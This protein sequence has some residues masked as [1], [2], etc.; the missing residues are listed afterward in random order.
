MYSYLDHGY[1]V[2]FAFNSCRQILGDVP[3]GGARGQNLGHLYKMIDTMINC[4][5]VFM[6]FTKSCQKAF[7]LRQKVPCKCQTLGSMCG[8]GVRG[9]NLGHL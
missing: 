3:R 5:L 9:Q 1:P 6:P 8:S 4:L 2:E 7:I